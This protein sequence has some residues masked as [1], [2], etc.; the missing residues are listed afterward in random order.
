MRQQRHSV[1]QIIGKVG[2]WGGGA[3]QQRREQ[4][5]RRTAGADGAAHDS[6]D[7]ASPIWHLLAAHF[8]RSA[9]RL[10]GGTPK[11]LPVLLAV[12]GRPNFAMPRS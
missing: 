5:H 4:C 3:W 8:V 2:G 6:N 9:R 7:F 11:C 10:D 12:T 1:E